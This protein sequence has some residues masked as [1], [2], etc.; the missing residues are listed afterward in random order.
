M[1]YASP[2]RTQCDSQV[3]R[4]ERWGH[5]PAPA[6]CG[7]MTNRPPLGGSPPTPT[8]QLASAVRR[9]AWR[10]S[11]ATRC[12][13]SEVREESLPLGE[14]VGPGRPS[15][16]R[17]PGPLPAARLCAPRATRIPPTRPS[18]FRA[19]DG[20]ERCDLS[21]A[22]PGES[23]RPLKGSRD[24]VLLARGRGRSDRHPCSQVPLLLQPEGPRDVPCG[25]SHLPTAVTRARSRK[26]P[27]ETQ[28]M[29]AGPTSPSRRTAPGRSCGCWRR[30]RGRDRGTHGWF[31]TGR[32][33][34]V[35]NP[36]RADGSG[37]A[38]SGPGVGVPTV[39][40][41]GAGAM[42]LVTDEGEPEAQVRPH[43]QRRP[44]T[45]APHREACGCARTPSAERPDT[46]RH[47][48]SQEHP[49]PRPPPLTPPP[50]KGAW[51]ALGN[52]PILGEGRA[53]TPGA[54]GILRCQ[55]VRGSMPPT[56]P[57]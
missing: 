52:W 33:G 48:E 23:P 28:S 36:P 32:G 6:S 26:P 43:G 18:V 22:G 15:V 41:G 3:L 2:P 4:G 24:S 38:R 54:W 21:P 20:S 46:P 7:R 29:E 31:P 13:G 39:G 40:G 27:R 45:D 57:P 9:P 35:R 55:R 30:G 34:A 44:D 53:H 11:G 14:A 1:K 47:P 49:A 25:Q 19:S 42:H 51:G 12:S 16:C 17:G 37:A 8:K 5:V 10:G 56:N 50:V